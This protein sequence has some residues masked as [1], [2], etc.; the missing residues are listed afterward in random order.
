MEGEVWVCITLIQSI[1]VRV[2]GYSL[3]QVVMLDMELREQ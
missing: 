3:A 2:E 1:S